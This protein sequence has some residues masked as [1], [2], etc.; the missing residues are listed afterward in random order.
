MLKVNG[1]SYY[2]TRACAFWVDFPNGL[3]HLLRKLIEK[4]ILEITG[5][6]EHSQFE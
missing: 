3:H 6:K 1:E 5:W 4:K 2:S